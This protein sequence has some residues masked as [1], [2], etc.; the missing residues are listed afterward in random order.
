MCIAGTQHRKGCPSDK[1]LQRIEIKR[2]DFQLGSVPDNLGA[3]TAA[4]ASGVDH[5]LRR[6]LQHPADHG[7]DD[8]WRGVKSALAPAFWTG[9]KAAQDVPEGIA[10]RT[11]QSLCLSKDGVCGL[12]NRFSLVTKLRFGRG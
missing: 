2:P 10:S 1:G 9:P 7:T 4:A 8:A 11:N 3:E 6:L 5:S 12:L